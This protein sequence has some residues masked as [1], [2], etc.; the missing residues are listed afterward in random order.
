MDFSQHCRT[1]QCEGDCGKSRGIWLIDAAVRH[2]KQR[3]L[4]VREALPC[5]VLSQ[6]AGRVEVLEKA[7]RYNGSRMRE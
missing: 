7:I 1:T 2:M 5:L 3:L 6:S 4:I